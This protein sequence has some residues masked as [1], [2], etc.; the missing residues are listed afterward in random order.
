MAQRRAMEKRGFDGQ[1]TKASPGTRSVDSRERLVTRA[2]LSSAKANSHTHTGLY[3]KSRVFHAF[4][5]CMF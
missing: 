1:F 2:K 4:L 5:I 3:E